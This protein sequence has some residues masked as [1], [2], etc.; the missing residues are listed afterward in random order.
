MRQQWQV[1]TGSRRALAAGAVVLLAAALAGCGSS[2]SAG[3]TT[4]TKAKAS[5]STTTEAKGTTT[6]VAADGTLSGSFV[7]TAITGYQPVAD[8]QL[9][10]AFEG[11]QMSANAG[12]NTLG[13]TYTFEGGVL[14]WSGTPRATMMACSDELM[15]QD[16]WLTDLF[17]KGV[18]ATLDG[19]TLT[20]T[21]GDVE[22]T[23]MAVT[24]SPLNGTTWML[25]GTIE[26]DTAVA[27]LPADADV[28]TL[29]IDDDGNAAIFTGCNRGSTTVEITDAT[30]TF[31]PIA[32]TKMACPGAGSEL[33][34]TVTKV[35]DG[36][37]DYTVDGDA[38]T[39]TN[40]SSGLVYRAS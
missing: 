40:G 11:D 26:A 13:S 21:S 22:I 5:A 15:A 34:A 25:D 7:G 14:A 10:L 32:L 1:R 29:T 19:S 4:T 33:E 18:D 27:S 3:G 35:L 12:C 9:T 31:G 28:P 38:L 30:L 23:L 39:I 20:L 2:D 37:V 8:T 16:A 17:T 6:T 24:E 36:E